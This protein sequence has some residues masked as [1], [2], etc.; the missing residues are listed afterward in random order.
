[1]RRTL[2]LSRVSVLT[3]IAS[4]GASHAISASAAPDGSHDAARSRQVATAVQ[5]T[6]VTEQFSCDYETF[7]RNI[8]SLLGRLNRADTALAA[9]D[10]EAAVNRLQASQGELGLMYFYSNDHGAL[11]PLIGQPLRKAVRYYLGNP[12]I[13]IQMTQFNQGAGLYAPLTMLVYEMAPGTVKVEYDR[14]SS[15]FAQFN[16]PRIDDVGKSLDSKIQ[17]LLVKADTCSTGH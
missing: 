16:D 3:L 8:M 2:H 6:H 11:F 17:A 10:R 4:A 14:P 5:I 9:T 15:M 7:T 1:M 12:L 13:A